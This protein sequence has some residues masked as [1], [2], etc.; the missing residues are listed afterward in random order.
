MRAIVTRLK[1]GNT[2]EKVLVDDWPDP[3]SPADNEVR[4][5]TIYSGITNG[6]ERNELLGG[7][8]AHA[9]EDLPATGGYQNV[10]K[11]SKWGL[12]FGI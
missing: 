5:R 6:T 2:R 3:E 9:D 8:Y 10:G 4:T 12:T 7:N 1:N 11:S